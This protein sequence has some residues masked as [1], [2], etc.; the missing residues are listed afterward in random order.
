MLIASSQVLPAMLFHGR[1]FITR[2]KKKKKKKSPDIY[3]IHGIENKERGRETGRVHIPCGSHYFWCA[4]RLGELENIILSG[5]FD[6]A[7]KNVRRGDDKSWCWGEETG[8]QGMSFVM[9]AIWLHPLS[10]H[11]LPICLLSHISPFFVCLNFHLFYLSCVLFFLFYFRHKFSYFCPST[12]WCII[13]LHTLAPTPL[14]QLYPFF[15]LISDSAHAKK[16]DGVYLNNLFCTPC[17][18]VISPSLLPLLLPPPSLPHRQISFQRT[19]RIQ[20]T[21]GAKNAHKI[22]GTEMENVN[23]LNRNIHMHTHVKMSSPQ[24]FQQFYFV[25]VWIFIEITVM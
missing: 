22:E 19:M 17:L 7:M 13:I 18:N 14:F 2:G 10:P 4:P 16:R 5:W 20:M 11:L 1:I 15:L 25:F 23:A 12:L 6:S 9:S 24:T 3:T 21:L 8:R